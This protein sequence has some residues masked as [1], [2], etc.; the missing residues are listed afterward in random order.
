M[1]DAMPPNGGIT[2]LP[3]G[4]RPEGT[5]GAERTKQRPGGLK[6]DAEGQRASPFSRIDLMR[7]GKAFS[8]IY[9]TTEEAC[10]RIKRNHPAG[11]FGG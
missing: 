10:V 7:R 3:I 11:P 6:Q 2:I 1:D 5:Y 8:F 4:K 9:F